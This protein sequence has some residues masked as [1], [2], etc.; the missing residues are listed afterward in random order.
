VLALQAKERE[1]YMKKDKEIDKD[2]LRGE[3]KKSDFPSGLVRGKY[4]ARLRESS[5]IIVLKPEVA[6]AFPNERAVNNAL[7]SL[8]DLARK[9]ALISKRSTGRAKK[10]RT[11]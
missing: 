4:A 3:Y 6:K 5:N 7:S 1:K 11:G 9:T 2:E 8:I 10:L